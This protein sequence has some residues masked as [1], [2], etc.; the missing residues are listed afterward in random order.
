MLS[1]PNPTGQDYEAVFNKFWNRDKPMSYPSLGGA[2]TTLYSDVDD[3][4]SLRPST[5][6]EDPLS[7]ILQN[8][9]YLLFQDKQKRC[10][11][12]ISTDPVI[13]TSHARIDTFVTFLTMALA[14]TFLYGSIWSLYYVQTPVKTL[15]LLTMWTV[16]FAAVL[17]SVTN[18]RRSEMFSVC[19][20]YAAVLVVFVSGNAGTSRGG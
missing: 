7:K 11:A 17:A 1:R 6:R 10:D 13:Y 18:S 4:I 20:A 16:L 2:S 19:A 15:G 9:F 8:R 14:A 3:L 5:Q 12:N